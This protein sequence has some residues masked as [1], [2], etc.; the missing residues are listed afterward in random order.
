M[1]SFG[2]G[3]RNV[4][5]RGWRYWFEHSSRDGQKWMDFSYILEIETRGSVDQLNAH[6]GR[7]SR[8]QDV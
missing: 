4:G 7:N 2:S 6:N 3:F 5:V 1:E 8:N